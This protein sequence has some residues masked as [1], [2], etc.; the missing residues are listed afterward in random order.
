MKMKL[1]AAFILQLLLVTTAMAAQFHTYEDTVD[2]SAGTPVNITYPSVVSVP[3]YE[4][5]HPTILSTPVDMSFT[6]NASSPA[7]TAAIYQ[8]KVTG[9]ADGSVT[10][11]INDA[12]M[13]KAISFRFRLESDLPLVDPLLTILLQGG[14]LDFAIFSIPLTTIGSLEYEGHFD[15]ANFGVSSTFTSATLLFTQSLNAATFE[16]S[17]LTYGASVPEPGTLLLWSVGIAGL[18]LMKRSRRSSAAEVA[19]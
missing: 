5:A 13:A 3:T 9:I 7:G 16:I 8:G 4:T 10:T 2:L 6:P 18:A 1:V 15:S 17:D 12:D 11:N 14:A 19:A